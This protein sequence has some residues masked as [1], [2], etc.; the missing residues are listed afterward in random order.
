MTSVNQRVLNTKCT[1]MIN[2]LNVHSLLVSNPSP[3]PPPCPQHHRFS[4]RILNIKYS[5]LAFKG[6][7]KLPQN[8]ETVLQKQDMEASRA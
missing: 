4:F 6:L 3:T 7:E 8:G 2:C 5:G 1:L